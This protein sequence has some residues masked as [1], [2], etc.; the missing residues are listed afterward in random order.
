MGELARLVA[1]SATPCLSVELAL[2]GCLSAYGQFGSLLIII[3]F[4]HEK[5]QRRRNGPHAGVTFREL[6]RANFNFA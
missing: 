4:C 1:L 6:V 2:F 3:R 5:I